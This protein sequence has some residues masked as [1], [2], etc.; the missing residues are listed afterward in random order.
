MTSEH[1]P[2]LVLNTNSGPVPGIPTT[3]SSRNGDMPAT[4]TP[5]RMG[6]R[7]AIVLAMLMFVL[8]GIAFYSGTRFPT[9]IETWT[10]SNADDSRSSSSSSAHGNNKNNQ[11]ATDST[12]FLKSS[13][14]SSKTTTTAT[15]STSAT[16]SVEYIA[17]QFISFTINTIGGIAAKGECDNPPRPVDPRNGFCYLGH[18]ENDDNVTQDIFHRLA[19]VEEVLHRIKL[20]AYRESPDIDHTDNVLKIVMLPE[21]FW[22]GPFGAYSTD[23]ITPP[24]DE[25][26]VEFSNQLRAMVADDFFADFLFVFGTIVAADTPNDVRQPW[27]MSSAQEIEFYNLATVHKG[28]GG[29][30][31]NAQRHFVVTKKYI[32]NAD[33]LSRT[34]LPNPKEDNK[35][36]YGD[37][38]WELQQMFDKRNI[39][40]ITDNILELDGIRFGIEICL[41]HRMGALWNH[42]QSYQLPLV[43]VLLVTSAG[44]AIERGPNPIVPGGVVYL[45]DGEASS[46]A[47]LRSDQNPAFSPNTVCRGN[48]GGLKHIP[49]GGPG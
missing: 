9:T 25:V 44:M 4:T 23:W 16:T 15:G 35:H 46:A 45:S 47:C 1:T 3:N 24:H 38:S 13:S 10:T 18:V 42:I 37:I 30:N 5:T 19:L 12:N 21:F 39:T 11:K 34:T 29:S 41:D 36:E 49:V 28:G 27:E 40:L 6:I 31:T 32:S 8:T 48:V 43:D 7:G 22:R 14:S 2:L 20:D 33:F 17:T 26:F